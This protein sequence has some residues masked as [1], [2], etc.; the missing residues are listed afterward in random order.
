MN[1]VLNL[2]LFYIAIYLIWTGNYTAWAYHVQSKSTSTPVENIVNQ[3]FVYPKYTTIKHIDNYH[4]FKVLD[5]YRNFEKLDSASTKQWI[6]AENQLTREYFTQHCPNLKSIKDHLTKLYNYPK[7]SVPREYNGLYFYLYNPGINNQSNLV[8]TDSLAKQPTTLIDPNFIN[9]DGTATISNYA[10]SQNGQYVAYG[11]SKVGS[12]W[13]DWHIREIVSNKDLSETLKW[14]KYNSVEW[15]KDNQGFYYTRFNKPMANKAYEEANY[16]HKVFYHKLNTTQEQDKL[17]Y[18]NKA[19]KEWYFSPH[20]SDD[21]RYLLLTI[22]V[23]DASNNRLYCM[24]LRNKAQGF[25]KLFDTP[26]AQYSFIGNN[27]NIFYIQTNYQHPHSRI[28]SLDI[29]NPKVTTEVVAESN[30]TIIDTVLASQRLILNTLKDASSKLF[31]FNLNDKIMHNLDLPALGTVSG[32]RGK[33]HDHDVYFNFA[34]YNYQPTI[35]QFNL[36][37]NSL[38]TPFSQESAQSNSYVVKE[39]FYKSKDN[40]PIPMFLCYK[41]NLKIDGNCPTLLYG[42]GGFDISIP[43]SYKP[44]ALTFMDMG[45]IYAVANLRGGGEY[46]ENWHKAGMKEKKQNVFDDFIY[47]AKWLIANKFTNPSKLAING[48]S[49]GGLLVGACLVQRPDLYACAI[50]SVGVMDMLRFQ[51]CTEGWAWTCE[52]GS[53]QNPID[54]KTLIK[55]SPYHNIKN[56]TCYPATLITTGDHD[57]RVVPWHSFKFAAKLQQ[58]QKCNNP[59]LIRIETNA[60]HGAGKPLAKVIEEM[61]DEL[62]FLRVNLSMNDTKLIN[63]K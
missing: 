19:N 51:N 41:E 21:G 18:E 36:T 59:I 14:I 37:T 54:F 40:T 46:G 63:D 26:N 15:T 1:K 25:K 62:A 38:N 47:A 44:F 16:Y 10:V 60:G 58:A 48:A 45:G 32:L 29:N 27:G 8:Y 53:A 3:K 5:N 9:K 13:Q 34:S 55:Y 49:N 39:I 2:V 31:I 50:P 30:V 28:I 12:D 33:E 61:T 57:D 42:Y 17:I 43:P 7:F 24:D 35:F 56:N 22:V 6:K 23:G 20:I 4:G 52:Y 11:I